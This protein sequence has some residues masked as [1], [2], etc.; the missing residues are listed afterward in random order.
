MKVQVLTKQV[1]NMK[2]PYKWRKLKMDS[3][4]ALICDK[5]V[6]VTAECS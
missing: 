3:V 4:T 6:K 1:Q 2:H 5:D